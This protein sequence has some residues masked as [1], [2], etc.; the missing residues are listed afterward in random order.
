MANVAE[1]VMEAGKKPESGEKHA[2]KAPEKRRALGRGLDSLLP[3]GPRV[4]AGT[5]VKA[6]PPAP[7]Q[8]AGPPATQDPQEKGSAAGSGGVAHGASVA[9]GTAESQIG[10]SVTSSV[11]TSQETRVDV[12]GASAVA[13]EASASDA[14]L[15][16]QGAASSSRTGVS[17]PHE[18]IELQGV[19][20]EVSGAD[21]HPGDGAATDISRT[22][23]SAPQGEFVG[24]IQA[25]AA[26][27]RTAEGFEVLDLPLDQIDKNPDQTRYFTQGDE[28]EL[29]DLA[30]SIKTQGVIQPITVRPG[31]DGRYILIAGAR[32]TRASRMAEQK[33]IPAIVR[34]VSDEQAAMMT[35]VENLMR[36]DLNCMDQTRAFVLLSTKFLLTQTQIADR[37][38]CSREKV[39]N[40]MRLARLPHQVQEWL[41]EGRLDYSHARVLLRIRDDEYLSKVAK[42]V[43][44][45]NIPVDQ[46]E[47]M[48]LGSHPEIPKEAPEV[49]ARGARWVDPNVKAAQRDLERA[50]G[51]R[52]R[53]RDR[54]NKG[55]ITIE[56]G[57]LDDFDRVVGMLRGK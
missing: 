21:A 43:V 19:V 34:E 17:A 42:R 23:A 47:E 22:R 50:L 46:L 7:A 56:Y 49:K 31:K 4:V 12:G 55:K 40:Y 57:S 35:I 16:D 27:R 15:G 33:T 28:L 37:V 51:M 14:H 53:I 10:T 1:K 44:E 5:A 41:K 3:G 32:R 13:E 48:M 29:V 26:R 54:H 25:S 24:D 2:E 45:E 11:A 9:S 36:E 18:M 52:V 6:A 38:G 8:A 30:E 20:E 39:T